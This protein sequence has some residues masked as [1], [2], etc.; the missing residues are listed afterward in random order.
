MA[1][2]MSLDIGE[3]ARLLAGAVDL[4]RLARKNVPGELE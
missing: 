3:I 2:T 1:S 4:D